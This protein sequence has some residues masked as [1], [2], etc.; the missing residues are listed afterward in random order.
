M[1][2][3]ALALATA[4]VLILAGCTGVPVADPSSPSGDSTSTSAT[5]TEPTTTAGGT[6]TAT[7]TTTVAGSSTGPPDPDEDRLGWED[8]Y[9]YNESLPITP[10]DGYD[11]SELEAL[12]ART[13]ARVELVREL[14]FTRNVD[15]EVI[16]REEYRRQNVFEQEPDPFQNQVYEATFLINESTDAADAFNE[17]YSGS[18]GGYYYDDQIVLV[19]NDPDA[20]QVDRATLAHELQHA[21]QDQHGLYVSRG[22]D[23]T[24]ASAARTALS[25]GEANFVMDRYQERCRSEWECIPEPEEG[26]STRSYNVGLFLTLFVPY[27]DGPTYVES[28][29]Q[30]GGWDAVGAAYDD[31]PLSTAQVI[32]PE[33]YPDED[34]VEVTVEDR[35]SGD[36][37]RMR[38]GSGVSD[39]LGEAVLYAM[40]WHNGVIEEDHLFSDER[41]YN[42]SHPITEGW[43]GDRVQPYRNGNQFGYVFETVWDTPADAREFR[44]AYLQLLDQQG[45]VELSDGVYRVP[46]DRPYGDAFRVELEGDTVRI[47]NAPTVEQLDEV[48]STDDR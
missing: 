10:D 6:G 12:L 41:R 46:K 37:R 28:L 38:G 35:S 15:V 19:S 30:R 7:T 13:M 25:E 39:T 48:H 47:V 20:T 32:H 34:P 21:L 43:A 44:D 5:T 2:R 42:Y 36:W 11:R 8:G 31:P 24:D 3:A 18:V 14:E 17:V 4:A 26:N 22:G 40:F 9:W 16:S 27:S 1:R 33:R 29:Y 45:A 23:T